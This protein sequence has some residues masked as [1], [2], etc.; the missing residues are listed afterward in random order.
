MSSARKNFFGTAL[1][2]I[3][4][5][6]LGA[7]IGALTFAVKERIIPNFSRQYDLT[8]VPEKSKQ[9]VAPALPDIT[10]YTSDVLASKIPPVAPGSVEF[11]PFKK[12]TLFD[13]MGMG[14]LMADF[15]QKQKNEDAVGI[16]IRS[17]VYDL[18]T[19]SIAVGNPNYLEKTPKGYVIKLPILIAPGATLIMRGIDKENRVSV[20]LAEETGTFISN[21]GNLIVLDADLVGWRMERNAPAWFKEKGDFRP[22]LTFWSGSRTYMAR[23]SFRN[24]GYDYAKAYGM[25]FTSSA[26]LLR[27]AP[28][29]ARATGWLIESE[30]EDLYYGFYCYEADDIA[31][32]RNEYKNNIVYNIDPHDDSR[33]LIIAHNNSHGAKIRHGIIISRRVDDS[34]IFNNHSHHNNGSGIMIERDSVNNVIANNISEYNGGDGLVFFESPDNVSWNNH[35]QFNG[36]S[37]IRIRNSWNIRLLNEK[38]HDNNG[39]AVLAYTMSLAKVKTRDPKL[40]PYG[41]RSGF[42]IIGAEINNNKA[43]NFNLMDVDQATFYNVLAFNTPEDHFD[44]DKAIK[45]IQF[46]L[47]ELASPDKEGVTVRQRNYTPEYSDYWDERHVRAKPIPIPADTK[48]VTLAEPVAPQIVNEATTESTADD[49]KPPEGKE[50][51]GD[52]EEDSEE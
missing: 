27:K 35:L 24:L 49:E 33:R 2:A 26:P 28:Q 45:D 3:A 6:S 5:L 41:M 1:F 23:S 34:W 52:S 32:I 25:T 44:G 10:G 4:T 37:G 13:Y 39:Y 38:I 36:K 7:G 29:T 20:R 21:F 51:S 16:E 17:G 40:D 12:S 22:Y 50:D 43:G 31:I 18:D 46:K 42:D 47:Y 15:A 30:I 9:M 8:Q 48:T 11:V 19:L 14:A